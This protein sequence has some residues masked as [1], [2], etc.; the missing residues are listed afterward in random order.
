MPAIVWA[1]AWSPLA[2]ATVR[3]SLPWMTRLG[4]GRPSAG[5]LAATARHRREGGRHAVGGLVGEPRVHRDGG[6]EV[7]VG[8]GRR[9]AAIAPPADSPATNTRSESTAHAVVVPTRS[10]TTAAIDAGS[11]A[12]R[13]LMPAVEPVPAALRVL[14][15]LLLRVHDDEAVAVGGVVHPRRGREGR[16]VLGAAVQH[17]DEPAR[18]IPGSPCAGVWTSAPALPSGRDGG[19]VR[20]PGTARVLARS[21]RDSTRRGP[22]NLFF[23]CAH[24]IKRVR[25]KVVRTSGA[26]P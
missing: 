6:E 20:Q 19:L 1:S 2:G 5:D 17:A 13:H 15:P 7:G 22:A 8:G 9:T 21:P 12:P 18:A 10:R 11:P 24:Y 23:S 25:E 14:A 3:S 26:P 16:R 4:T